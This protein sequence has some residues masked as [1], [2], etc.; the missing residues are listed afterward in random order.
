[1]DYV[2][3]LATSGVTNMYDAFETAFRV[4]KQSQEASSTVSCNSAIPFFTDGELNVPNQ[5]NIDNQAVLDL[6]ARGLNDTSNGHPT[7][8]M[9]YS[10]GSS[11]A[12]THDLLLACSHE[13]GVHS[14]I[15]I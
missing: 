8:L 4:L 14:K 6:V 2:D 10:L 11:A 5:P 3:N 9:T 7:V 1:V 13:F 12:A 15:G